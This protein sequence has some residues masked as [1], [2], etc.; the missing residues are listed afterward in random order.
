MGGGL[1]RLLLPLL[2]EGATVRFALPQAVVD[3]SV[4]FILLGVAG[5]VDAGGTGLAAGRFAV[6]HGCVS[7]REYVAEAGV[8]NDGC[9]IVRL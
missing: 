2:N 6:L 5:R 9:A 4:M 3:G 7:W 8:A 1:S